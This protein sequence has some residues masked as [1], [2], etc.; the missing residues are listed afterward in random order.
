MSK[1]RVVVVQEGETIMLTVPGWE[2]KACIYVDLSRDGKLL[3]AGGADIIESI[4]GEG[5]QSKIAK[6]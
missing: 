5:M 6:R 1:P 2:G 3:L 4:L